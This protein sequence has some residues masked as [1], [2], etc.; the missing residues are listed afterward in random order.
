[1]NANNYTQGQTL[2]QAPRAVNPSCFN[3]LDGALAVCGATSERAVRL[4]DRL[5][6]ATPEASSG[7]PASDPNGLFDTVERQADH[8]RE[9][10]SLINAALDRL[11]NKLP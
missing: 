3:A 1:M 6:G 2:N 10:M 8:I 9:S 11:E 4:I 7:K 5:C